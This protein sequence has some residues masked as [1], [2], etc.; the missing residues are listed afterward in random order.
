MKRRAHF[1]HKLEH[2]GTRSIMGLNDTI[3]SFLT[4]QDFDPDHTGYVQCLMELCYIKNNSPCY[5]NLLLQLLNTITND[6]V[7]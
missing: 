6:I 2:Y 7:I 4:D 3:W 5:T 1:C